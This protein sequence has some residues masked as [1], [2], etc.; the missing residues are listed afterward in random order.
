MITATYAPSA[1]STRDPQHQPDNAL[2][3]DYWPQKTILGVIPTGE[4]KQGLVSLNLVP[5]GQSDTKKAMQKVIEAH[6]TTKAK[7][8]ADRAKTADIPA[9]F[10]ATFGT[11]NTYQLYSS[12]GNLYK[13][14]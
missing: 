9:N 8:Y 7:L 6:N 3:I 4:P 13:L 11:M 2:T 14:G 12:T 10:S 5:Y 1:N